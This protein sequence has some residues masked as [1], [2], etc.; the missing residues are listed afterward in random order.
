MCMHSQ[1][2]I[3]LDF[4]AYDVDDLFGQTGNV[5]VAQVDCDAGLLLLQL[6]AREC[7]KAARARF[8]TWASVGESWLIASDINAA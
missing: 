5:L 6:A 2:C 4:G 8:T 1:A 3:P 7:S